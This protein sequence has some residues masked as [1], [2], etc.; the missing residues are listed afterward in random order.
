MKTNRILFETILV[1]SIAVGGMVLIP[2][3]KMIFALIP[4]VYLLVERPLR[5]HTWADIGFKFSTF[6]QDLR[7]NWGWFLLAGVIIQPLTAFLARSFAPAYL[8][9]VIS[10][11]PFPQDINWFVLIP[12]L[13]I[14]LIFEEMTFRSLIQGRLTPFIG[15]TSAIVLTSFLFAI[16][17]FNPGVFSVVAIDLVTLFIDS[18]LYG[19]IYA[20]SNNLIV[21]WVAH[22]FGDVLGMIFLLSL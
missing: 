10:R 18:I 8:Q 5:R 20:R 12:V 14:S 6:W 7:D 4:V 3:A 15:K 22:L 1:G 17:H 2:Q 13:A 16:A 11:L 19:I 21:V 9:H